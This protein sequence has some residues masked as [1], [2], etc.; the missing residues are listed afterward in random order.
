MNKE[1]KVG[2]LLPR[3]IRNDPN[4]SSLWTIKNFAMMLSHG[5]SQVGKGFS[6]NARTVSQNMNKETFCP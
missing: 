5:Q 6:I 4:Y 3:Y 2:C 1:P